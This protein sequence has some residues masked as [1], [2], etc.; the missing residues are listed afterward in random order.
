MLWGTLHSKKTANTRFCFEVC[1]GALFKGSDPLEPIP[2]PHV[3]FVNW[4][5]PHT[6]GDQT[7]LPE[8]ETFNRLLISMSLCPC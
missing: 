8:S 6:P 2:R 3:P 7:R 5:Q 1:V 4:T